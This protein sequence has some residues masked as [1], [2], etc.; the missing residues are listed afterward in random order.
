MPSRDEIPT[1]DWNIL[2]RLTWLAAAGHH[3]SDT[4]SIRTGLP[5]FGPEQFRPQGTQNDKACPDGRAGTENAGF[6]LAGSV[7]GIV[8]DLP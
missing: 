8:E 6:S 5:L 1:P 4:C 2:K 7:G 3:D